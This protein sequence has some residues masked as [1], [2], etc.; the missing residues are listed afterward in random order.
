MKVLLV[1]DVKKIG[2]LGDVVEVNT[3][4]ARNYL[5]PQRLAVTAT[6]ANL[7]S[8][9]EEK[10]RRAEQRIAGRK[11]LEQ[12]AEAVDGAEAV[13]AARANEL[14]HLFGSVTADQIAANL[15]EQG[16]EVADEVV[17]LPEHIKQVGECGVTL[18]FAD[19]TT[20][21]VNVVVVA[22]QEQE[23]ES[24]NQNR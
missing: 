19:D 10:A 4:Y 21:T 2:W 7:K 12:A 6:E 11:R 16:F 3:G 18:K 15:R 5:L 9:A 24:T 17:K 13:I 14:G 1:S 20:A 23:S 22:E 8:I